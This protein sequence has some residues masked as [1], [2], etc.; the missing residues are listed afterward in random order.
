MLVTRPLPLSVVAVRPS[1]MMAFPAARPRLTAWP[2]AE[3]APNNAKAT[4]SSAELRIRARF[5]RPPAA[6]RLAPGDIPF[7]SARG[8][9][10]IQRQRFG[11]RRTHPSGNVKRQI[12]A[13]GPS[14]AP[15]VRG[16]TLQ[17]AVKADFSSAHKDISRRQCD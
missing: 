14:H 6:T 17:F 3:D 11:R 2:K 4:G 15:P 12:F 1:G 8:D 5:A 9:S 7:P 16:A 10:A 13:K